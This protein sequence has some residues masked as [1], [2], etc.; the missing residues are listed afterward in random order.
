VTIR[1]G[2]SLEQGAGEVAALSRRTVFEVF[3][4]FLLFRC[5]AAEVF[6]LWGSC[7]VLVVDWYPTL[8]DYLAVSPRHLRITETSLYL[9]A[10]FKK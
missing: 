9:S 6:F 4:E 1:L 3:R 8:R 5:D 7:A 2:N 10:L